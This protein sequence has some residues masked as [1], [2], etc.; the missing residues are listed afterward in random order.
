[1]TKKKQTAREQEK[2]L[3]EKFK[4]RKLRSA[5]TVRMNRELNRE[6]IDRFIR[7]K[8]CPL[9]TNKF[10]CGDLENHN[11]KK[12][13]EKQCHC[14]DFINCPAYNQYLSFGIR[15]NRRGVTESIEDEANAKN[16]N[17]TAG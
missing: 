12:G 15:Q 4:K 11:L 2:E 16:E 13:E 5:N 3:E 9:L 7:M 1:M 6:I 8:H 14:P 17:E 10:E